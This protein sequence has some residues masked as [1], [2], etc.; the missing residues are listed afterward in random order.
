MK[1]F[2]LLGA[3]AGAVVPWYF[4]V[5]TFTEGPAFTAY[6]FFM[7]GFEGPPMLGSLAADF[8]IGATV[9]SVWMMAEGRRRGMKWL[10]GYIVW[11][12]MVA[13]ASA[14]P[15]FLFMRERHIE[16]QPRGR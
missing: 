13:W 16:S 14:L 3:I 6:G 8:W 9:S 12:L 1:Y 15:L 2:Y 5:L 10:P 7:Q 11:A 4:N